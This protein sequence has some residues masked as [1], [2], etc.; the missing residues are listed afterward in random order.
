MYINYTTALNSKQDFS[1]TPEELL[2]KLLDPDDPLIECYELI[3]TTSWIKPYFDLDLDQNKPEQQK[4]WNKYSQNPKE[5]INTS[6]DFL[7]TYFPDG[8]FAI[9]QCNRM[10]KLSYHIVVCNYKCKMNDLVTLK[11]HFPNKCWD[12]SIYRSEGSNPQKFRTIKS[13]KTK[14]QKQIQEIIPTTYTGEIGDEGWYELLNHFVTN[15]DDSA[16]EF[17]PPKLNEKPLCLLDEIECKATSVAKIITIG[18]LLINNDTVDRK[19]WIK[20]GTS[21]AILYDES[22]AKDE[23]LK[24]SQRHSRFDQK[25]FDETWE[26]IKKFEFKRGGWNVIKIHL[27]KIHWKQFAPNY[28]YAPGASDETT[29]AKFIAKNF[30]QYEIKCFYFHQ[31]KN[32]GKTWYKFVNHRWI[33]TSDT[34]IIYDVIIE[35]LDKRYNSDLKSIATKSELTNDEKQKEQLDKRHEEMAKAKTI[36]KTCNKQKQIM[37]QL[38]ILFEDQHFK[39]RLDQNPYLLGFT[40]GVYDLQHKT[41]RNGRPDDYINKSTGYDYVEVENVDSKAI[42]YLESRLKEIFIG[43]GD[44]GL[45]DSVIKCLARCLVG[46]N[47][48][49]NQLFY[50]WYGEGSNAKSTIKTLLEEVLGDYM[51]NVPTTYLTQKTQR[52]DGTNMEVVRM[53]GTRI[54]AMSENELNADINIATLKNHTGEKVI[55]Y[56]ENYGSMRHSTITWNIL[57]LTNEKLSL[58]DGDSAISRRVRMIPFWAKFVDDPAAHKKHKEFSYFPKDDNFINN[59]AKYKLAFLHILL[60][61]LDAG[62]KIQFPDWVLKST[63]DMIKGQDKL[64]CLI[65]N[66]FEKAPEQY[67]ISWLDMKKII[68]KDKM[69]HQLKFNSDHDMQD[70]ILKRLSY[71]NLV[72][73]SNTKSYLSNVSFDDLGYNF[74][75][76][77]LKSKKFFSGIKVRNDRLDDDCYL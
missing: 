5:F 56:R 2:E 48:T 9:S 6:L 31:E 3:P 36:I 66:N 29:L 69:F 19:E 76:V 21:L 50:C 47:A 60:K 52:A 12:T 43:N 54:V 27:P 59:I 73:N 28:E 16:K 67:G 39:E 41:F 11:T 61:E 7:K 4:L 8:D 71:A 17:I 14:D 33:C 35:W 65:E 1:K 46:N 55:P 32:S 77:E 70:K 58:P 18:D 62:Y 13:I 37:T 10:D 24:F 25:K 74:E 20:I 45:Y 44:K 68:K 38:F 49:T 40:N 34:S 26:S 72:V 22:K 15:A 57:M 75:I 30:D 53:V 51:V 42:E 23:F 63:E 64:T